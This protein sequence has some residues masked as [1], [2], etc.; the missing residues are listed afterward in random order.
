MTRKEL[1]T[2]ALAVAVGTA[3][4]AAEGEE[5][6]SENPAASEAPLEAATADETIAVTDLEAAEKIAGLEFTAEQRAS[7]LPSVRG[8]QKT[9]QA[10]RADK[11]PYTIEPAT[12]FRPL[13]GASHTKFRVRATPSSNSSVTREGLSD[14]QI[15]FL[16]VRILSALVRNRQLSPVEL[17]RIYLARLKQY[18]PKLLCVITLTEA[19]AI[20]QSEKAE[21]EIAA[22]RYRGPLHG[23]PYGIK[24]L[25]ATRGIPT[26]WGAEPYEKQ[27]F[28]YNCTVVERLEAAGAILLAK[29]SMGALAMDDHW[30]QG[31]TKRPQHCTIAAVAAC[32]GY[33]ISFTARSA[34]NVVP[35]H[36]KAAR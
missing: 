32:L 16:P 4:S 6:T 31:K 36:K 15:A 27:V 14:E 19:L 11:I 34:P 35:I 22:G 13:G 10:L 30:F 7:I 23:I 25:F 28:D 3:V 26:T 24:D 29:L 1:L 12:H 5:T 9:F 21:R 2:S 33:E 18:S 17:T 20:K 8:L